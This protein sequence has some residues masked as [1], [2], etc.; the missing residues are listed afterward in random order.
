M[1]DG[2]SVTYAQPADSMS[3]NSHGIVL[4][5]LSSHFAMLRVASLL[6]KDSIL[7]RGTPNDLLQGLKA[8]RLGDMVIGTRLSWVETEAVEK[9]DVGLGPMALVVGVSDHSDLMKAH[10]VDDLLL[11]SKDGFHGWIGQGCD[12]G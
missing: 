1:S 3:T 9:R 11:R 7:T 4:L 10:G 6:G 2:K 8:R 5:V 12:E